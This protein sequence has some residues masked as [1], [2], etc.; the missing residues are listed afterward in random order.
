LGKVFANL[1]GIC[2]QLD[3]NFNFTATAR[4]YARKAL[5]SELR[6]TNTLMEFYNT[7]L[8]LRSFLFSLPGNLDRLLRK[9]IEGSLRVEFKHQGLEQLSDT[10]RASTNRLSIALIVGAIII[11]SSL[12]VVAD[13]GPLSVFGLPV[14]GIAGYILASFFGVWLIISI[15]RSGGHK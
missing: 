5:Q 14:L 11:G 8:G 1:E 7:L 13:R 12:V 2:R 3:P 10:F 9:A 15:L 6:G 4:S